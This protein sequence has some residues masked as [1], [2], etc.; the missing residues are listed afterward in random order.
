MGVCPIEKIVKFG[1]LD[2]FGISLHTP[3]LL[4]VGTGFPLA[5]HHHRGYIEALFL[6]ARVW[7]VLFRLGFRIGAKSSKKVFSRRLRL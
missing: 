3:L 2:C 7:T 1:I 5:M 4:W 6:V